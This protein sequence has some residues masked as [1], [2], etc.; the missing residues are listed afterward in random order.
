[1]GYTTDF[2]GAFNLSPA[3]TPEQVKYINQ[4]SGTRRLG[5]N[6]NTLKELFNGEHG[7]N[8]EYGIDGE[9]FV[10]GGGYRGQGRDASVIDHNTQ[11]STQ[12]SLWCQWILTDDG[13][14]LVW[15]EVE[16]FYS[17]TE[18][19]TYMVEKFFTPWGIKLNGSVEFQGEDD[20]DKGVI[21]LKDSA[22]A[23]AEQNQAPTGSGCYSEGIIS[24]D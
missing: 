12:P 8:G 11:P 10:G 7:L 14:Q 4:F 1:M 6:V 24:L 2:T 18:W 15:D 19:L 5:R 21:T 22:I 9:F 17:Y 3:A 16:K 13:T 20:D 23:E